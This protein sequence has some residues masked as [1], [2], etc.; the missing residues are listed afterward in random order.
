[1]VF[2]VSPDAANGYAGGLS[3]GFHQQLKFIAIHRY[4][5]KIEKT[6]ENLLN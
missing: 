1:M 5:L 4:Y 2:P 6:I 3:R